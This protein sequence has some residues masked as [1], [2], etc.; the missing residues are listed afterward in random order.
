MDALSWMLSASSSLCKYRGQMMGPIGTRHLGQRNPLGPKQKGGFE[1]NF[2]MSPHTQ[3]TQVLTPLILAQPSQ[4][5]SLS[6]FSAS[7]AM[8]SQLSGAQQPSLSLFAA[9]ASL[10]SFLFLS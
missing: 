3:R 9:P 1:Y 5:T 4:A 10:G 2:L 7:K 6:P 8:E